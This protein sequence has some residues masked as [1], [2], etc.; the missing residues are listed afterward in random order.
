MRIVLFGPNGQVGSALMA[1]LPRTW[2]VIPLGRKDVDLLVPGAAAKAIQSIRPDVVI[3]AAAWTAVDK[4]E[5]DV[6]SAVRINK[7]AP[8]E[9]ARAG[10]PWLISYS[11]D[12]VFDGQ[13]RG[14]YKEEDNPAPLNVYGAS[15][16]A[17]ER[18][19]E[20]AASKYLIF[21]TSWVHSPHHA[22]F[23]ITILRLAAERDYLRVVDDQIGA[24]TSATLIANATVAA[25]QRL[26]ASAPIAS[27]IYH[28]AASGSSSWCDYA[29]FILSCARE[30][31]LDL[32]CEI[33][34]VST[35]QY[36]QAV[37]RPANSRL[38]TSKLKSALQLT[39]PPW[40]EGVRTTVSKSLSFDPQAKTFLSEGQG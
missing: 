20:T 31:G 21:R 23:I 5:A 34:P 14:S 16:L 26:S 40:E 12:Y 33:R 28:L 3:N 17:G 35:A 22:N 39:F 36:G 30:E 7:D 8:A 10:M 32:A 4:A 24:P 2:T 38:D 15:K 18:E 9:M 27:G 11:T 37:A 25:L 29:K 1:S 6:A 13:K 19:I